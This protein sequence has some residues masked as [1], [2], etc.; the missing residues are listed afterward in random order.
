LSNFRPSFPQFPIRPL[1]RLSLFK[2]SVRFGTNSLVFKFLCLPPRL[3][4]LY[5]GYDTVFADPVAAV[6]QVRY[7]PFAAY[8][9]GNPPTDLT[10]VPDL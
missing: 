3:F 2:N 5:S 4:L 6:E 9:A 10:K 7:T 8:G 1:H